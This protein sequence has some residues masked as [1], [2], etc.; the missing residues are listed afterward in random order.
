MTVTADVV[1]AAGDVVALGLEDVG[2][3]E[4]ERRLVAAHDEHVREALGVDTEQRPDAV[5]VLV[6]Q[7]DAVLA[8]D[9][10][11]GAR[12]LH[13]EPGGVDQQVQR[14]HLAVEHRSLGAISVMPLRTVFDGSWTC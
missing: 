9:A 4:I 12:L 1:D 5:G 10:V 8:H 14:V 2:Q 6:L 3:V 11:P 13:L 7:V